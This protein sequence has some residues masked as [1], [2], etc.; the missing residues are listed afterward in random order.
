MRYLWLWHGMPWGF[1]S[2]R[3]GILSIRLHQSPNWAI[4]LIRGINQIWVFACT[5]EQ[6]FI[7][8]SL[9]DTRRIFGNLISSARIYRV[10]PV[11][12]IGV[13]RELYDPTRN[14]LLARLFSNTRCAERRV[15]FYCVAPRCNTIWSNWIA[16]INFQFKFNSFVRYDIETNGASSIN[17]HS[18]DLHSPAYLCTNRTL[19]IALAVRTPLFLCTTLTTNLI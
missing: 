5:N 14:S 13:D 16:D 3:V 17:Y 6:R 10:H 12:E 11:Y 18:S 1:N 8:F 4:C 9:G 7:K 2:N 19:S 15:K